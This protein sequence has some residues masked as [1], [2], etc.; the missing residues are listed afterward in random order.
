[1]Y[2]FYPSNRTKYNFF[3]H[4]FFFFMRIV[5]CTVEET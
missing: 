4:F 5:H 3:S 2:L 1:M